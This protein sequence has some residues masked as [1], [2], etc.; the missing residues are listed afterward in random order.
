MVL[1]LYFIQFLYGSLNTR[2]L[3]FLFLPRQQLIKLYYME[4]INIFFY[5]SQTQESKKTCCVK[6]NQVF[7]FVLVFFT[8]DF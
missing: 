4:N 7:I 8:F 2:F 1:K 5:L 3:Q 6:N